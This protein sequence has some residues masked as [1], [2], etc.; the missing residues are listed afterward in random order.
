M[1]ALDRKLLR[2]LRT[3]W[4]QALTI[5]LVV[6][7]GVAG[8]LTT[9]SAVD[10]LQAARDRFYADAHFA[11]V[12]AGVKRAPL[13]LA[14]E[15]RALPGVADVQTSLEMAVRVELESGSEPIVGQM[16]GVD[17]RRPARLNRVTLRGAR[18][19]DTAPATPGP[20][21][22]DGTLPVWVSEAFATAHGLR[23]GARLSALINGKR[24]HLQLAAV[25]LSPEYVFAG[26]WGMPDQRGFG[27]FWVDHQALA[28]AFDMTGAFNQLALKL[29][30]HGSERS[31]TDALD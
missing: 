8:F 30:P 25:A 20:P 26:L 19:G 22:T 5:A 13:A 9:L 18:P 12:F 29:A 21:L 1:K 15:L 3:L 14:E 31:V 16:I 23:P 24:R 28:A 27:V 6:A 11:D 4:S 10:S 2:D 7:S 17:P